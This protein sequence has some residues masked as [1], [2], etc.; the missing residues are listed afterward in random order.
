[1]FI[2]LAGGP[3]SQVYMLFN[4]IKLGLKFLFF[5]LKT[6]FST[7][8]LPKTAIKHIR[9]CDNPIIVLKNQKIISKTEINPKSNQAQ[10][11][12]FTNF[13][14]KKTPNMNS[15]HQMEP[16]DTNINC[17]GVNNIFLSLLLEFDDLSQ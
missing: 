12:F 10:I 4:F 3:G 7:H 1:M 13:K 9:N 8:F 17:F 5:Y 6:Y 2:G 11:C 16:F 15:H 14:G